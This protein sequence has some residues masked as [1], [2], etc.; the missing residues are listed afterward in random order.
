MEE[1]LIKRQRQNIIIGSIIYIVIGT[2]ITLASIFAFDTLVN[3]FFTCI[4]LAIIVM[5]LLPFVIACYGI[6][7]DKRYLF[8]LLSSII[9]I[10]FGCL[11]IFKHDT[12]I[13]IISAVYLILLPIVRIIISKNMLEQLKKE[14]PLFLVAVLMIFNVMHAVLRVVLIIVG[15]LLIIYGLYMLIRCLLKKNNRNDKNPHDRIVI[16]ADVNE[17]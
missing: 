2:L 11:F 13:T 4:G 8:D 9:A 1:F 15:V 12:A 10:V 16:D 17:L 7:K 3:I 5:N 14:L 6:A